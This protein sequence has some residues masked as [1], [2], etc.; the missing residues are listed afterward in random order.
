MND[1][2]RVRLVGGPFDGHRRT[3]SQDELVDHIWVTKCANCGS[4]WYARE[5]RDAEVYRRDIREDGW[6]IYV[7]TSAGID[8]LARRELAYA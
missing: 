8:D 1:D 3:C 7:F 4:H 2:I 5:V 6:Q